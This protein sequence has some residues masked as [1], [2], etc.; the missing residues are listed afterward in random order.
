MPQRK[1]GCFGVSLFTREWIEIP[2]SFV[3]VTI[4]LSP[5]LR[6][7]GLKSCYYYSTTKRALSL[8]L[9]EGVD[10]N[11]ITSVELKLRKVSLFTREWI[12]MQTFI[13]CIACARS[14]PLYEGVDWNR[15][16]G[17]EM[18]LCN[19]LPLYEG[20]DWNAC[21]FEGLQLVFG[22]PLYEGV[23]W[24]LPCR[25]CRDCHLVSLFTR[26]WIEIPKLSAYTLDAM[27]SLFTR[28]WIESL[29]S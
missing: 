17:V 27:V 2:V 12:E 9:Y 28:E 21:C 25:T 13:K 15:W 4:S 8:P 6:G 22:L 18:D 19:G 7:S 10:W 16:W 24:N 5:S 23:D 3:I 26:E 14:L 1:K 20:V 11:T 29:C